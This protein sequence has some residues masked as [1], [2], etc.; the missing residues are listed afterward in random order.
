MVLQHL[1]KFL[2]TCPRQ[3]T[4]RI[5]QEMY[6]CVSD[7]AAVER[8]LS[9]LELHRPNFAYIAKN[10]FS[11]PSQTWRVHSRLVLEPCKL[12]CADMGLGSAL[13]M[14]ARFRMPTGKRD[15]QWLSQRD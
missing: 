6:K 8:M 3:E 11:Q 1:E 14:S 12:T 13:D 9:I 4:E 10:P 15:E 7:M 5:D 2:E